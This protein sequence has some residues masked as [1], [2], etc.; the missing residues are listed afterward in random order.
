MWTMDRD[1]KRFS[2]VR[3][4]VVLTCVLCLFRCGS[5]T[6]I[7]QL[8]G[9]HPIY[10]RSARIGSNGNEMDHWTLSAAPSTL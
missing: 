9:R 7:F 10:G 6:H 1:G 3:W 4:V 8:C 5:S 2:G